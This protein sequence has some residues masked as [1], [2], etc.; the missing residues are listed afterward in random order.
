MQAELLS[1]SH[2]GP[3]AMG[4]GRVALGKWHVLSMQAELP[5][6]ILYHKCYLC[7]PQETHL[8]TL[9]AKAASL[10]SFFLNL[11]QQTGDG[12]PAEGKVRQLQWERWGQE[13]D[14]TPAESGRDDKQR[15]GGAGAEGTR[16][17][18]ARCWSSGRRQ[19]SDARGSGCRR[20]REEPWVNKA[21]H[22]H[23]RQQKIPKSLTSFQILLTFCCS[24]PLHVLSP[25]HPH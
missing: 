7:L 20:D 1:L 14:E 21:S 17:Q 6:L 11:C 5:H 22:S 16:A 24:V 8:G 15:A 25:L 9:S 2:C 4:P 18:P 3:M 23:Q 13:R 19:V 10:Q 12:T